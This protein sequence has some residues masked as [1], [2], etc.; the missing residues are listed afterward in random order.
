MTHEYP[1]G[2]T[3][4][5]AIICFTHKLVLDRFTELVCGHNKTEHANYCDITAQIIN[6]KEKKIEMVN[7]SGFEWTYTLIWF[8]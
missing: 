3:E 7:C 1:N 4:N 8:I 2:L 5:T 6:G